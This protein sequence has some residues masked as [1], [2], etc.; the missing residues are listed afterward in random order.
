LNRKLIFL[1]LGALVLLAGLMIA[2]GSSP[3]GSLI[4]LL[5]GSLGSPAAIGGTLREATPLLLLGLA[6]FLGLRAGLFNIGAEGQFL[7]GA[8]VCA[9][10]NL[11]IPGLGG[12]VLG[13]AGGA[14]AGALWAL[15]AGLIKAYRNGHE[16]ITTIMLNSVAV[17]LTTALVA[18]PLKDPTQDT[19]TTANLAPGSRLPW[20]YSHPPFQVSSGLLVGLVLTLV[21][22]YWLR[23]TVSGYELQAV[24][25]NPGAARFAGIDNRQ[26]TLRAM[27]S[28]GAV[29]GIAG[30][31]QVLAYDGR[32]YAGI[33][34]GYGFDALGVAL[35]AGSSAWGVVPASL[36]FG[37][38]A[39]GGTALQLDEVPK[40]ITTVVL[41]LIILIAAALRFRKVTAND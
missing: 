15:P 36:L 18:G 13:A 25:A 22:A 35:L 14:V 37:V 39:K 9:W 32:F 38:L 26:V 33:S 29:A 40:G 1:V 4:T 16:V 6:V 34:P 20:L 24:G 21:I 23:K 30:V 28:S 2:S 8:M 5:K 27:C 3:I 10:V 19:P 12:L 41:G 7:L 17:Y 11:R 31:V